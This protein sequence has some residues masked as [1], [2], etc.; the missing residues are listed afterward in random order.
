MLKQA[1]ATLHDNVLKDRSRWDVDSAAL[2]GND[3]NSA[4]ECHTTAE[5]DGTSDSEV[6]QLQHLGD[7]GDSL[8]EV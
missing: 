6:I 5:V 8:L 7:G 1:Q 3:D 4:L 2:C